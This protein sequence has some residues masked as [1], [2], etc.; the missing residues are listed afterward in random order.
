MKIREI[1]VEGG[2]IWH[3]NLATARI[4]RDLVAPTVGFL[5]QITGLPLMNNMLGSTGIK[6]DSSDIDL[7]VDATKTS[8]EQLIAKLKAWAAQNDELAQVKKTGISV[9]FR[10][11]I[12]G[13]PELSSVQ[14]DFM[15]VND[16]NFSKW[17]LKLSHDSKY[18]NS[19]RNIL[20]ASLSKA[21]GLR[22][23][24]EKGL[25]NRNTNE[26]VKNGTNP[27]Y[28]AKAILNPK[29]TAKDLS[30]AENILL[31]LNNDPKRE[32]K[33]GD[34]RK[35]LPMYGVDPEALK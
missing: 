17:V 20:L 10:C 18:K 9:H 24:P 11:P 22:F 4:P 31:A 15:F 35:T 2:N 6:A 16:M 1:I 29:A 3:G 21:V 25:L 23:S 5:E 12:A 30:S 19:V 28:I 32:E 33:L 8:K 13:K 14:V 27:D 34:A 7:A 26:P